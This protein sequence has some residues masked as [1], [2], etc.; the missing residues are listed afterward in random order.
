M[1][2]WSSTLFYYLLHRMRFKRFLSKPR[3]P[4]N[5][6]TI[7]SGLQLFYQVDKHGGDPVRWF[8]IAPR[9]KD[10]EL[11]IFYLHG[12]AFVNGVHPLHL[13]F[14]RHLVDKLH[15]EV[16]LA[17][18]PLAPEHSVRDVRDF[19]DPLYREF[20]RD[21]PDRCCMVMGDSAGG[22]LALGISQ[23]WSADPEM[24]PHA[25]VLLSPWLD[26][27]MSNSEIID[28]ERDDPV[29]SKGN[30]SRYARWYSGEVPLDD[31][32]V[33]PLY[34]DLLGLPP[35]FLLTGTAD[36]LN[37]D[38]R[39]LLSMMQVSDSEITYEEYE[40]MIHVWFFFDF[41][42]E[43]RDARESLLA[44]IRL[45]LGRWNADKTNPASD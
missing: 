30:L 18:Y 42:A 8:T 21:R 4:S 9:V 43:T 20:R 10:P 11:S 16:L 25:A 24:K 2:K 29:L 12:G 23:R 45:Q 34:G 31:P 36:I 39:R 17:R 32:L 6:E 37:P 19:L 22:N 38:A 44:F 5:I 14:I 40:R 28:V 33:S 35:T 13:V 27:T 26:L 41:F 3:G 1:S 15:C 7:L